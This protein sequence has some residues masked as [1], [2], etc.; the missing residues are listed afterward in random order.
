MTNELNTT[1]I[2]TPTIDSTNENLSTR[3][4]MEKNWD[5]FVH[6]EEQGDE[7][8]DSFDETPAETMPQEEPSFDAVSYLNESFEG[9]KETLKPRGIASLKE[10]LESL[11]ELEKLYVNSPKEV[12]QK[13]ALG[14]GY[15]LPKQE[16]AVDI[17]TAYALK[18]N[19]PHE[20]MIQAM[21]AKQPSF[22]ML[23][24]GVNQKESPLTKASFQQLIKEEL[25]AYFKEKNQEAKKAKNSSFSPQGVGSKTSSTSGYTSSGKPKT[26]R[27][28]L[29]E[30]W[31]LLGL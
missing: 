12:I 1:E 17:L 6:E 10:W 22:P 25:N 16:K 19:I 2:E 5:L 18:N 4:I 20:K 29:E 24:E 15:A 14:A 9:L 27:E 7:T 26:T 21:Q 28:I 30:G 11:V 8:P 31:R 23:K 13:L 3:E